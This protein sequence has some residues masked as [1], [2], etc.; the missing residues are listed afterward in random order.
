[1]CFSDE[2]YGV[3]VTCLQDKWEKRKHLV[4]GF[5]NHVVIGVHNLLDIK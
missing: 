5:Y 1:M 3:F 2:A 4:E